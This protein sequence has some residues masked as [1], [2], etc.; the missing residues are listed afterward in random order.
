MTNLDQVANRRPWWLTA[1]AWTC[2][3][4]GIHLPIVPGV[5]AWVLLPVC[6]EIGWGPV[7][8]TREGF[9]LAAGLVA[10]CLGTATMMVAGLAFH[11]R[12]GRRGA[13]L[14]GLTLGL[15]IVSSVP[16]F[17]GQH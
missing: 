5:I 7:L 17:L 16:F 1:S 3:I 4:I 14:L 11:K 6:R 2:W 13:W 12:E 15:A 8:Q 9:S 10:S